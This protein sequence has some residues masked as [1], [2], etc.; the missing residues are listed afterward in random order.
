MSRDASGL[1]LQLTPGVGLAAW[2]RAGLLKREVEYYR[3]LARCV[4]PVVFVSDMPDADENGI[5]VIANEHST[6]W[7]LFALRAA[8]ELAARTPP[9]RIIKTN[10]LSGALLP[11]LARLRGIR[12]VARAGYVASEPWRYAHRWSPARVRAL[13]SERIL[14]SMADIVLVT[15]AEAAAYLAKRHGV[16]RARI[17]VVPNHVDV[18]AFA[19]PRQPIPGLVTMVGRL[20]PEKNIANALEAVKRVP[21]ARLRLVGDGPLRGALEQQAADGAPLELL[22]GVAHARLPELLAE[23]DLF[24]IASLFEG[25]PKSLIEAMASGAPCVATPAP[26]VS[27]ALDH[28]VSGWVAEGTDPDELADALSRVL[29]DD[30]LK[31]RLGERARE[32]AKRYSRE[33]VLELECEAYRHASLIS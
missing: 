3:E 22:G 14:V 27:G 23:T 6:P 31:L 7:P 2:A 10:Q 20:A 32:A 5:P 28:D 19:G 9:P 13:V 12:I 29:G 24:L 15:T 4:G 8:R 11:V 30:P 33:R 1:A 21:G 18:V 26:G 17:A 25:H 16:D